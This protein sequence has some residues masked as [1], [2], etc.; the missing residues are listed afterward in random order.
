[1]KK[2]L[3][4]VVTSAFLGFAATASAGIPV[5]IGGGGESGQYI[6]F[7]REICEHMGPLYQCKAKVTDGSIANKN[8]IMNGQLNVGI[9]MGALVEKWKNEDPDFNAKVVVVRK[10]QVSEA[11]FAYAPQAVA[12]NLVNWEGFRKEKNAFTLQQV[13][14]P[15]KES[16]DYAIFNM[17]TLDNGEKMADVITAIPIKNRLDQVK[18]VSAGQASFGVVAQF[19]DPENMF[20][21]WVA[22]N[23]FGLI[24]VVDESLQVEYPDSFKIE[25]VRVENASLL[26]WRGGKEIETTVVPVTIIAINPDSIADEKQRRMQQMII[27]KIQE[28]PEEDLVPKVSWMQKQLNKRAKSVIST[29]DKAKEYTKSLKEKAANAGEGL[30]NLVNKYTK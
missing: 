4:A 6:K 24:P 3:S 13:I 7:A 22:E 17:L 25:K 29:A 12:D 9:A 1:M 21:K 5:N 15:S 2:F 23:G 8:G 18:A 14:T 19:P 10:T 30:E 27:E 26:K 20:F 28:L 11:L 16:G